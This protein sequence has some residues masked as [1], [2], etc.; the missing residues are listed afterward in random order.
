M[1]N[2]FLC[3]IGVLIL[4]LSFCG[5]YGQK[6]EFII[7]QQ[8]Q[9]LESKIFDFANRYLDSDAPRAATASVDGSEF[10]TSLDLEKMEFYGKSNAYLTLGLHKNAKDQQFIR[11]ASWLIT[12]Q[13]ESKN[14]TRVI[15][16]LTDIVPDQWS[17]KEVNT[18]TTTSTGKLEEEVRAFLLNKAK[19]STARKENDDENPIDSTAVPIEEAATTV[20]YPETEMSVRD[21]LKI[22]TSKSLQKL[23]GKQFLSLPTA[24]AQITQLLNTK[25]T[26]KSCDGCINNSYNNWDFDDVNLIHAKMADGTEYY[27]LQYYGDGKLKGL[28][29]DLVFN[30]SSPGEC[31]GKFARYNPQLYQTTVAVDEM[32]SAA[33]TVVDFK[34]EK[35]FVRLEFANDYLSRV[36][37]SNKEID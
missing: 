4:C 20:A 26:L 25:P 2:R 14:S 8:L 34:Q 28:P 13:K 29:F 5:V 35:K 19:R 33:V 32:T 31:K 7:P 36:I 30:D 12:L 16:K 22:R 11:R 17:K 27:A 6:T 1:K 21:N 9:D 15:M 37:V 10:S 3:I 24:P 18:K 23:F